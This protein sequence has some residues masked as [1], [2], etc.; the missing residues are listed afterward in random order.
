MAE[1]KQNKNRFRKRNEESKNQK[2]GFNPKLK[3]LII[4]IVAYL[5]GL[6]VIVG[7]LIHDLLIL[8]GSIVFVIGLVSLITSRKKNK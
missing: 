2:D 5:L 7:G 3:L 4:G 1:K 6:Y 8:G